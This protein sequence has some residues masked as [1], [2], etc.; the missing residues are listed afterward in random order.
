[1]QVFKVS[2][3]MV[4]VLASAEPA[5]SLFAG[6]VIA[7]RPPRGR[8][9][10]WLAAGAA[11]LFLALVVASLVGRSKHPFVPVL[12]VLFVGGFASALYNIFQTTIVIDATPDRLRSR[13]MGLVTVCIGTWPLGTMIAGALSRPL[14]SL[15]ALGAL[16][17]CGLVGLGLIAAV[18]RPR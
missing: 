15:G 18:A 2:S 12:A 17:G 10:L 3:A 8:P 13:M 7:L 9:I 1:L 6:L 5:G 11:G 14:G 16:G 4:G